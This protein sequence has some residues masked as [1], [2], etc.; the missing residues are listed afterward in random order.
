MRRNISCECLNEKS[1]NCTHISLSRTRLHEWWWWWRSS[2][3]YIVF[4]VYMRTHKRMNSVN[5]KL[6]NRM[7]NLKWSCQKRLDTFDWHAANLTNSICV[8][9]PFN[10]TLA[11]RLSKTIFLSFSLL[12]WF[13]DLEE[14]RLILKYSILHIRWQPDWLLS[15]AM[16]IDHVLFIQILTHKISRPNWRVL[17]SDEQKT[18]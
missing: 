18:A 17:Q 10:A 8:S 3:C 11:N 4:N 13:V 6:L 1:S 5:A 12:N 16:I 15:S 14:I 7:Y 9:L 2:K